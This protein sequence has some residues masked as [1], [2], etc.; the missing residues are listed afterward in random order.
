MAA[1]I[2]LSMFIWNSMKQTL[3]D[4][5]HGPIISPLLFTIFFSNLVTFENLCVYFGRISISLELPVWIL[6][7][8]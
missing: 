2:N 7:S 4:L 8:A 1:P 3:L 6:I 5:L